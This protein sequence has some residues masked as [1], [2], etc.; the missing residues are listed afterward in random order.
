[1]GVTISDWRPAQIAL[2]IGFACKLLI[3]R[4]GL[5]ISAVMPQPAVT[6]NPNN[7]KL[8][9]ICCMMGLTY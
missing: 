8:D 4:L 3:D 7:N 9:L 1:M 5:P 6:I 2:A